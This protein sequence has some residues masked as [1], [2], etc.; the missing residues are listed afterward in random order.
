MHNVFVRMGFV[1]G[2]SSGREYMSGESLMDR[3]DGRSALEA[4]IRTKNGSK[5]TKYCQL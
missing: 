5:I 2:S 3:D 4:Y 1:D